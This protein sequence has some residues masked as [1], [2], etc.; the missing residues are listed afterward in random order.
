MCIIPHPNYIWMFIIPI[1]KKNSG[2]AIA[3]ALSMFIIPIKKKSSGRA[4]ALALSM[5][6]RCLKRMFIIPVTLQ[7]HLNPS[8]NCSS[9]I[10]NA[11]PS[12]WAI[13]ALFRVLARPAK[14]ARPIFMHPRKPTTPLTVTLATT[15]PHNGG[16]ILYTGQGLRSPGATRQRT[17][18]LKERS[19]PK[20]SCYRPDLEVTRLQNCYL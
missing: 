10:A 11:W 6:K 13:S 5:D 4:I 12:E 1:K 3:L 2:R 15:R 9:G 19:A 14:A 20:R 18:D 7:P 8:V 17:H 16:T